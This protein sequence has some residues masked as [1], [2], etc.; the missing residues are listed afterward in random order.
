MGREKQKPF[1]P[2]IELRQ[3]GPS[4]EP[5][6]AHDLINRPSSRLYPAQALVSWEY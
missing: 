5:L 1:L 4:L 6:Q 2:V 3:R